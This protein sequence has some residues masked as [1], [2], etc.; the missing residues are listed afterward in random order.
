MSGN[1]II[2]IERINNELNDIEKI[3]SRV[4]KGFILAKRKPEDQDFFLESVA[5][6]MHDFYSGIERIFQNI[7]NVID[8]N[9][10]SSKEWHRDLLQQMNLEIPGL[11]PKII[12]KDLLM[13]LNEFLGFRHVVRNVYTFEFNPKRIEDLVN[14]IRISF[15]DLKEQIENFNNFLKS[16]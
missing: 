2:L 10:P 16:I 6:N 11:R 9:L 12:S 15:N 13:Q 7:A 14:N 3:V 5:L 1:H 4:E 8:K